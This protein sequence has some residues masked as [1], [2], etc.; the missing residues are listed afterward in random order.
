VC[1]SEFVKGRKHKQKDQISKQPAKGKGYR[2]KAIIGVLVTFLLVSIAV[3]A[4]YVPIS[5]KAEY[6]GEIELLTISINT[7]RPEFDEL[8]LILEVVNGRVSVDKLHLHSYDR[9]L[10]YHSLI[11]K[12]E[13]G[14]GYFIMKTFML[15]KGQLE[16]LNHGFALLID[17]RY[18]RQWVKYFFG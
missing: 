12:Q 17:Y 2:K 3:P 9:H 8:H 16:D 18:G 1:G 15:E 13:Y 11:V 7:E 6:T 10:R 14:T 5:H 4:I